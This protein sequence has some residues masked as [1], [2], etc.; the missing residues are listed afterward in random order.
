M[1]FNKRH[2]ARDEAEQRLVDNCFDGNR[3]PLA[4]P[5]KAAHRVHWL[6]KE[7][8]DSPLTAKKELFTIACGSKVDNPSLAS[9]NIDN[10]TCYDCVLIYLGVPT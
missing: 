1:R 3:H 10:C 6:H 8:I 2:V 7:P 4:G 9:K 5:V